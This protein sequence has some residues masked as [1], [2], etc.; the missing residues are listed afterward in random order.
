LAIALAVTGFLNDPLRLVAPL[1]LILIVVM[2]GWTALVNR[3]AA[4]TVAAGLSIVALVVLVVMLILGSPVRLALLVG[5]VLISIAA[6]RV[7]LGHDLAHSRAAVQSV[8]P[9]R[10]GVLIMSRR[11]SAAAARRCGSA[12]FP[13]RYGSARR[14]MRPA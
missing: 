12:P 14:S 4:R 6:A 2:A 7:A 9:A 10:H 8:G 3:G 13:A 1:L 11:R 5:L